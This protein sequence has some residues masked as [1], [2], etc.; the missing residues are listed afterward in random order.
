MRRAVRHEE[1]RRSL[2]ESHRARKQ[3][4]E[5]IVGKTPEMRTIF[6][7]IKDIA[8]T[9]ASVLIQGESGTGKEL[10][11]KAIHN[12]SRRK[13]QP[14]IVI[15]CSAY[16]ATLLESELFGHEK[17]AFTGATH[18]KTGRFEQATGGT[19]FLDE[20]GEISSSAQIK[21][22][23]VLQTHQF[24]R[25]GGNDTISVDVRIISATNRNL[26]QEVKKGNFREDLYYR[27]KVIPITVPALRQ[28]R[29]DIPVL[30]RHFLKRFSEEQGLSI[31]KFSSDA[32]RCLLDHHWPGNVRELENTVEHAVVLAKSSTINVF[33]LPSSLNDDNTNNAVSPG[34]IS[35]NEARLLQETLQECGWNKKKAA[36]RLGISR[37]TLYRKLKKYRIVQPTL[38]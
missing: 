32:M 28:R 38:H 30:A 2:G 14:F 5:G 12:R 4:F 27:L 20:I 22:L 21:L 23:R 17:G 29:N 37:N 3:A 36:Q 19:V 33:D 35:Q 18:R 8:P 6:R 31:D 9:D 7:V 16:P 13:V 25:L 26:L 1:E 11:A 34:S 15:N 24:E 10:V